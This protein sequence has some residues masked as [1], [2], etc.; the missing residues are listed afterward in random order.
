MP[1]NDLYNHHI[2]LQPL[3]SLSID[4]TGLSNEVIELVMTQ[5]EV[6]RAAAVQALRNNTNDIVNAII[7]LTM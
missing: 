5:A 6:T 3:Q 2:P 1:P 7:D 4:E